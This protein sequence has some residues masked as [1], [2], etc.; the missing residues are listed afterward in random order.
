MKLPHPLIEKVKSG[1][2][3]LFLGSGALFGAKLPNDRKIPL[4]N[5]LRDILNERFLNGEFSGESLSVVSEMAISAY[6]L[7]EVQTY[8]A[9]YF[10]GVIPAEFHFEI[11]K[12]KWS[13]IFT[14]N[15]DRLI[16][17]CYEKS[18][19]SSQKLIPFLSDEQDIESHSISPS[20]LPLIKLHGCITRTHD[21]SLPLIL[22]IDQYNQYKNN[23]TGLFK[24]LFETAYKNTIVFVGHSL[25]DANIRS[26]LH[27]LETEAPNGERHYL[28]KPELR[29]VERDFW[30]Q[31]KITALDMTF[32][33][34]IYELNL[35][36]SP[37]DRVL[38]K[39]ISPDT[40]FI[41]QFFNTNLPPS[42]ELII[43][44]ERDFTILHNTMS[45]KAC[46][47]KDFFRGVDQE[48]SPIVDN[49]AITRSIQSIIYDSVIIKPDSERKIKTEFYVVKGEAGSGKS[50]LL[51][52]LAWETMQ[53][54]I[55]VAIWVNSGRPLD[56]DLIEELSSKS[57]ERLFVFWDDAANNAIEIN[58]FV[59]KAIKRDLK[60]TIV[61]AERYNEW[62]MRC[63]EL[64]EQITDKF[65]LRYLSE[66]EIEALVDSLELHDSLG[67]ILVNKS[68]EERCSELRDRHGRQLLVA[69]HEA[70]MGEPFED[71]IYNEY[72]NIFPERAKSIYLTVCVLNRLKVPVRA[73]LISRVH[74]I[75]F[76]DFKSNLYYPLEKV[77]VSKT[78]GNDDTFYSARH[79]EIAEIVF[80]R[81]LEKSED[82]YLEYISILSKLNISFSSD[83]DSYRLL[84]K[85]RS[86]QEL[87][88]DLDDVVA[89]YKHAHSVFG[90]DPYLLQQMANY[91]RIRVNGSL[92]KAIELLVT[93]SDSAPNDSSILHSLA[94]CWRDK[95][96]KTK[97]QS[98]LS[99]AIGEAR[100]YLQK[101]VHKWGDSSYV[102]ST[103]IELSIISLKNLLSDDSSPLKL[104]N[105]SIRK[106]QQE[107]TD[108]KQKFPSSGH[109]YKLEAQFSELIN[110]N[111]NALKALQRSFE[112]NDR[113][114]YLAIR[115]SEIYLEA[116]KLDEAKKVLEMALER[117]R[118]D[119]SLNFHYAELLRNYTEPDQ[120]ELI[121]FY[122]RAFTPK[123]RNYH[124]QF[125][126]ARFSFFSSDKKNHKQSIEI[127]DHIRNGRFSLEVRHEVRDYDGGKQNPRIHSGTIS[128]KREGF[129]FLIMDGTG[130]EIFVPAKQVKDDLW[131]AIEEGDRVN[132]NIAFSFSGPFAANLTPV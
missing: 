4:G 131:N 42:E 9:E 100:G 33:D 60:I 132:F 125:W 7:S 23:R 128:R 27:E 51:R 44:S 74:E 114:P 8:I 30:G 99:L 81:A 1:R 95:A 15:Y 121:Y 16:E 93:A 43:S 29:D 90:D 77:V 123:D 67:P 34:F 62:N 45:V 108:N 71:I 116:S 46:V 64:D 63:E 28:L 97:D 115:L 107:L 47:A 31:K 117:R 72:S 41:Q 14:T 56:I 5:D 76:E 59:S 96:E 35:Q 12:F 65:I 6:S 104:I 130:Y 127:F 37:E 26:V 84:I 80:K 94:V 54:K 87:F 40:H 32:E 78:Y 112:E 50:V 79:S 98:H 19:D 2:V 3:V 106:V 21:E 25:Q 85:A 57:G 89:I 18:A 83:R 101:I 69:L 58:R 73:G 66:K 11:P 49:V 82:K 13:T 113:E 17:T 52:Q 105:E 88:P 36:I 129:G 103:S 110:D 75:T 124:A 39:F 122:R 70:T 126:F 91:E 119:H 22:T 92:D 38:S 48:W 68:R 102:S 24:Y 10:S 111:E 120:S 55:G 61:S 53:S 86:L 118:S 109:I 20:E